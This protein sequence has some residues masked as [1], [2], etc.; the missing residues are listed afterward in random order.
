MNIINTILKFITNFFRKK[1]LYKFSE[2]QYEDF[3]KYQD[4]CLE[5]LTNS[6]GILSKAN[7]KYKEFSD[8]IRD[9]KND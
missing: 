9:N 3:E 4:T 8:F 6:N 7:K 1:K 5:L 2:K